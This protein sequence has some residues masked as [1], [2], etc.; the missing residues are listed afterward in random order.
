VQTSLVMFSER[1]LNFLIAAGALQGL[2]LCCALLALAARSKNVA[3]R[4]LAGFVGAFSLVVTGDVLVQTGVILQVPHFYQLFDALIFCLGPLCFGYVRALLGM[5]SR[6]ARK[7]FAHFVPGLAL[8]AL[9]L[10]NILQ[11]TAAKRL[12]I[13]ADLAIT[14]SPHIDPLIFVIGLQVLAYLL[15]CIAL[16]RRYWRELEGE[17]SNIERFKLA[18]LAQ[19]LAFCALVWAIW[20]VSIVF[21]A[22]WADLVAQLA[23]GVGIYALGYCGLRQPQL[24]AYVEMASPP[25][26]AAPADTLA[27]LT[28]N[29]SRAAASANPDFA[30]ADLASADLVRADLARVDLANTEPEPASAFSTAQEVVAKSPMTSLPKYAKSGVSDFE[31]AQV[32]TE[33][34]TLMATELLFL[35]PELSLA[36]LAARLKISPHLLSQTLNVH[37]RMSFFEYV[38]RLRVQE[39]QRCFGDPAFAAQSILAIALASGFA[40]KATFNATFKRLT[41]QTPSAAR[42]ALLG[43]SSGG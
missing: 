15:C 5:P 8:F 21:H 37:F 31:M 16:M 32:G 40:S 29:Q 9:L 10:P 14:P 18:W 1:G 27:A 33:L 42:F 36:E 13:T 35:E 11:S 24:W 20:M 39:V 30:S 12:M 4:W 25:A 6:S 3:L 41:G 2:L 19:L 23:L 7:L 22:R 28:V 26:D 34:K 43:G 38:N 17:Y